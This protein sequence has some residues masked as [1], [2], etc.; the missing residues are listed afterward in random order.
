M[1]RMVVVKFH[2]KIACIPVWSF[3]NS[4]IYEVLCKVNKPHN[5]YYVSI[6]KNYFNKR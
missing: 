3:S 5:P 1:G 6:V 4:P 2:G